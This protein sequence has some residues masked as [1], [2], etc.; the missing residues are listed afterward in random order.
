MHNA[1]IAAVLVVLFVPHLALA[2]TSFIQETLWSV[3]NAVFGFFAWLGGQTLNYAV[4][5][6]V[7]GFG[8]NFLES[9]TGNSVNILWTVVRDVFNLT[10]IFGLV[11]I[12]LKLIL[13]NGD[14]RARSMLISLILAALLVNFSLFI[15]KF[16][17]D[18]SN[19][20][21][22]QIAAA[23]PLQNGTHSVS[24]SFMN[25]LGFNE[26]FSPGATL[27]KIAG[28]SASY[29]YIFSTMFLY[30]ILAF[31]FMA[32]GIMLIIRYIVLIIYMIL[33]PVM[34]LGWV[35]PGMASV[36][37]SYWTKFM[38]RAFFA[39]AYLLMLYFA[40]QVLVS[41]QGAN[42]M[43]TG[44]YGAVFS[45][46]TGTVGNNFGAVIPFFFMTA[47]FLIASL[48]VAQ[49]MGTVGASTAISAGQKLRGYTQRAVGSST[50]GAAG[51]VG[52]N[53]VGRVAD[54]AAG[55]A[56]FNRLASKNFIA[57][58]ALKATRG[59]SDSSFDA[60][61][62]NGFGKAVGIGEGSKG[63][64][65]SN[66]KAKQKADVEFAKS[67]K[68]N[69]LSRGVDG[70]LLNDP[71]G[72]LQKRIDE[73]KEAQRKDTKTEYGY[74][75]QKLKEAKEKEESAKAAAKESLDKAEASRKEI[76]RLKK[77]NEDAIQRQDGAT[78]DALDEKI[79]LEELNLKNLETENQSTRATLVEA[80]K[81]AKKAKEA[82]AKAATAARE[83]AESKVVYANQLEFIARREKEA[84]R[85]SSA[86]GLA[87]SVVAGAAAGATVGAFAGPAGAVIGATVGAFAGPAAA[88]R[89]GGR[90]KAGASEL[91]KQ[92]GTDGTVKKKSSQKEKELKIL[93]EQMKEAGVEPKA[94][95][96]G[97]DK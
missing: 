53:T 80:E 42:G 73:D 77:E 45:G 37:H 20:A 5:H 92:Y 21:A 28:S 22:A 74:A 91:R 70:K 75:N 58:G 4:T 48:V 65:S 89:E 94:D 18:F 82:D 17:I 54:K 56:T 64:Y 6:Y 7:V 51:A 9:G 52:R 36:S 81:A 19:I 25:I 95:A 93:S 67:L 26:L 41:M 15:T 85:W 71:D 96:A 14:S 76:A 59:V 83:S 86:K 69:D 1:L 87:G 88:F 33:S 38:S 34:F 3:V 72:K 32:G 11:Y 49:K 30:I 79:K 57:A 29:T 63:G 66:I 61:R 68:E 90:A 35:F 44:S 40:N 8:H 16:V 39:P 78:S 10:F 24:S 60:R 97:D 13:N 27:S 12:G 55:S 43:N 47:G 84:T 2:Q 23:F 50:F 31:V 62:V 46:Q